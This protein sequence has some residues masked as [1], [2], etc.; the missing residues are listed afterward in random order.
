LE[1]SLDRYLYPSAV[2]VIESNINKL[3]FNSDNSRELSV[4]FDS[5]NPG[6]LEKLI[7]ILKS[8]AINKDYLKTQSFQELIQTNY[9]TEENEVNYKRFINIFVL[10]SVEDDNLIHPSIGKFLENFYLENVY[11]KFLHY[12][13]NSLN[14]Q[15]FYNSIKQLN[16]PIILEELQDN[17]ILNI[18]VK[19]VK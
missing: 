12:E 13:T 4:F 14:S 8:F 10:K 19:N 17:K 6:N 16:S 9:F 2:R 1:E 7:I 5:K 18:V 15:E 11:V 3:E